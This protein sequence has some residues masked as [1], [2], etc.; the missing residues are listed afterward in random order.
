MDHI[1]LVLP[2]FMVPW[3]AVFAALGAVCAMFTAAGLRLW[4]GK[5][6]RG[7]G[8]FFP[9]A[10]LF[11]LVL[12]RLAHWYSHPMIYGGFRAAMTDFTSG[13][14]SL[15]GAFLGTA[16]AAVLC[17]LAG[18]VE[19][20]AAFLDA[21][22]P[23]GLFGIA[24]GRLGAITDLSDRVR[25]LVASPALRCLPFAAP[26]P[27]GEWRFATFA[28]QALVCALLGILALDQFFLRTR[29]GRPAGQVF[30]PALTLYAAAEIVLDSTRYDAD[31]FRFNGFIHVPQILCLAV[32]YSVRSV[33]KN[34]RKPFHW[35]VWGVF[36]LALLAGGGMEY[37]VQRRPDRC[38]AAYA[39]MS[40]AM[41]T[42]AGAV[43]ALSGAF[44]R[45]REG[46]EAP[47]E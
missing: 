9:A 33:R 34:G 11:S 1:A 4:Q 39:A 42:A 23:A 44:R 5:S 20:P 36:L 26:A 29:R 15:S 32:W 25:F 30:L 43:L 28:V 14:F 22:T 16:L 10:I 21:L 31:F 35:I 45:R 2:R 47:S 27:G 40:A 3:T 13:G 6:L 38:A 7:M 18:L 12:G 24:V 41:I 8:L 46:P 37:L 19:D 17:R